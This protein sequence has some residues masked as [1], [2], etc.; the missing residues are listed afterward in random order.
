V[1]SA[2]DWPLCIDW[3][4]LI[5]ESDNQPTDEWSAADVAA[6]RLLRPLTDRYA[7]R[8]H[9]CTRESGWSPACTPRGMQHRMFPFLMAA[10]AFLSCGGRHNPAQAPYL[11]LVEVEATYG[12]LITAGNHPTLDQN[13][14]GERVGL[15]RDANGSVW[16]LPVTVVEVGTVLACAPPALHDQKVT[17][18]FPQGSTVIGSTNEPTGW[19][20]GTGKLEILLRDASGTVRWQT[21]R[22]GQVATG[23]LCWVPESPGAPQQLHYYRLQEARAISESRAP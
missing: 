20:G 6:L 21:V 8:I 4:A 13:G 11:P 23:P 10:S 7:I 3:S 15:F 17:D 9:R 14:T 16:G 18:T 5:N 12:K 1:G 2:R 19:R 22:G